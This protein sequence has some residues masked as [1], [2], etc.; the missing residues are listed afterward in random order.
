MTIV[1]ILIFLSYA[2]IKRS[3]KKIIISQGI[4]RKKLSKLHRTTRKRFT[5]MIKTNRDF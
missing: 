5:G 1:D 2:P 3:P 4:L